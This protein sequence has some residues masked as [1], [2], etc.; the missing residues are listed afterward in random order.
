MTQE[1]P[2]CILC[3]SLGECETASQKF[4]AEEYNTQLPSAVSLLELVK[5]MRPTGSRERKVLRCPGCGAWFLYETDYE[6]LVN[7]SEDEQTLAR[8]SAE[9]AEKHLASPENS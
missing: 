3:S 8:L 6:Y 1:H 4:G 2:K 7:G 5:D 9:E